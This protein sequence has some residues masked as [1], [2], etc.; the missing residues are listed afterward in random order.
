MGLPPIAYSRSTKHEHDLALVGSLYR[1]WRFLVWCV[2]IVQVSCLGTSAL[3]PSGSCFS[4][5][6]DHFII[7]PSVRLGTR[8]ARAHASTDPGNLLAPPPPPKDAR[9]AACV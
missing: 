7:V 6:L 8:S 9:S 4:S 1:L 5:P 3:A 2:F